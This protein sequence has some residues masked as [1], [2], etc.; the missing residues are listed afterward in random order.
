VITTSTIRVRSHRDLIVWQKG[1][2]LVDEIYDLAGE[3]PLEERFGLRSQFTRAAVSV[4]SNIAEGRARSTSK[5]FANFLIIATGSLM[6]IDTLLEV[7]IRRQFV[8]EDK[9]ARAFSLLTEIS[10]MLTVLHARIRTRKG[11]RF[12]PGH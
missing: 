1:M 9:A 12:V 3:L 5:D 8:T 11:S 7:A 2:D 4:P 10:K 6:E